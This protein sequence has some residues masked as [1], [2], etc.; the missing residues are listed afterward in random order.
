MYIWYFKMNRNIPLLWWLNCSFRPQHST[1]LVYMR[2]KTSKEPVVNTNTNLAI[3]INLVT[4][5]S[6]F[7]FLVSFSWHF[8]NLSCKLR[9]KAIP[10][11]P[12]TK[13]QLSSVTA[14]CFNVSFKNLATYH[15]KLT[16]LRWIAEYKAGCFHL[17]Y[18]VHNMNTQQKIVIWTGDNSSVNTL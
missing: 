18:C 2:H 14:I 6:Q 8:L 9:I 7:P 1:Y 17:N 4:P 13:S 12:S 11:V 16:S 3:I 5:C 15:I 10:F